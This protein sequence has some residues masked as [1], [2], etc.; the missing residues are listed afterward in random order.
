MYLDGKHQ[1]LVLLCSHSLLDA[2]FLEDI[3]FKKNAGGITGRSLSIGSCP[4]EYFW[5]GLNAFQ[6]VKIVFQ[7]T[8]G[9]PPIVSFQ[10]QITIVDLD[11]SGM[12]DNISL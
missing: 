1:T 3:V 5:D 12:E 7:D 9:V 4:T 8:I 10:D 2:C 11:K 6:S